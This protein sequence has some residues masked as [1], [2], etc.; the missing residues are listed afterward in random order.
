MLRPV[1]IVRKKMKKNNQKS[2]LVKLSL[3]TLTLAS[4]A[5]FLSSSNADN[6]LVEVSAWSGNQ[7]PNI[8]TYYA[9]ITPDT[10]GD[11]LK[12][13]LKKIISSPFSPSYD[14]SRYEALDETE[15]DS[16][17]VLLIY[18][19]INDLK[20]NHVNGSKGWNREHTFPQSKMSAPATS[21]NHIIFADDNKT[22]SSR[23]NK[24]FADLKKTGNRVKDGYGNLTDNYT[25]KI[26]RAHV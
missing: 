7:T 9:S 8:G 22:N 26:G 10:S 16:S 18:S 15:G 19:R 12:S 25:N 5:G 14:W 21:D 1:N 24:K 2:L 17:K 23:G 4:I 6:Q 13:A 3:L 11:T 20:S